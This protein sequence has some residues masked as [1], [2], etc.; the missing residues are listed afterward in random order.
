MEWANAKKFVLVLLVLLNVVLAVLYQ[1]QKRENVM[2]SVQEKVTFEVL[3]KNGITM[4]T[5]LITEHEPMRRL[6]CRNPIYTKERLEKIFFDG[7]KTI[8]IPSEGKILYRGEEA[9][10]TMQGAKGEVVYDISVGKDGLSKEDAL[11]QAERY[12]KHLDREFHHFA[13]YG[14]QEQENGYCVKFFQKYEDKYIFSNYMWLYVSKEGIYRVE[15]CDCPVEG[16]V[17]ERKDIFYADEA[18]LTFMRVWKQIK[19]EQNATIQRMDLGYIAV[20]SSGKSADGSGSYAVPCY[21]ISVMEQEE[22]FIINAYTC[23]IMD[24]QKEIQKN[25][26]DDSTAS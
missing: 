25:T 6:I 19:P 21:V 16:Y 17:G 15:F 23:Q 10:L 7:Q 5:D 3:S 12:M 24:M 1:R 26:K 8:V 18:L 20:E 13:L 22:P 11:E 2:T 9:I 4:Y 14:I